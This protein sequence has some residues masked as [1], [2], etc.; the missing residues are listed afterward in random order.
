MADENIEEVEGM[1]LNAN[2]NEFQGKKKFGIHVNPREGK[3]FWVNGWGDKVPEDV[4]VGDLINIKFKMVI[5]GDNVYRNY[6]E[7]TVLRRD[8]ATGGP[9]QDQAPAETPSAT[10]SDDFSIRNIAMGHAVRLCGPL[11]DIG[12]M[13]DGPFFKKVKLIEEYLRNGTVPKDKLGE[14]E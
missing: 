1:V 10:P 5:D 8:D 6:K 12:V 3:S 13:T 2:V 4:A 9:P 14:D 7:L 11:D